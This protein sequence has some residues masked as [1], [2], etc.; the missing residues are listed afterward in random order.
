MVLRD[1]AISFQLL[2]F[3]SIFLIDL[4]LDQLDPG[5]CALVGSHPLLGSDLVPQARNLQTPLDL[6]IMLRLFQT[7]LRIQRITLG[8]IARLSISP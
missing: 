7:P 3:R 1:L 6:R 2:D 8:F 5:C 4:V